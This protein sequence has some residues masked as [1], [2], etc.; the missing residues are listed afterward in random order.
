MNAFSGMGRSL[1]VQGTTG[2]QCDIS[3]APWNQTY[4]VHS[5]SNTHHHGNSTGT[6]E[7]SSVSGL[8]IGAILSVIAD[9]T[10]AVALSIQKL[11]HTRN[12]DEEGNPK[13]HFIKVP[14]WWIGMLMNIFG[15]L[16]NLLAYGFAPASLVAP[17]GCVGVFANEIIAVVFLKEPFRKQDVVG[18]VGVIIG[19]IL[20][21]FGVPESGEALDAHR[22]MSIDPPEYY[23]NPR[24]YV[25]LIFL[26]LLIAFFI[27]YLE[28]RYAAAAQFRRNSGANCGAILAQF[29]RNSLTRSPFSSLPR[30]ARRHLAVWLLLCSMISS[31]TVIA[32]RGWSSLLTQVPDDCFSGLEHCFHGE[33]HHACS[34]TLGTW[35]FWVRI[36]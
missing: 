13:K 10:I 15:E 24:A 25:Y 31:I 7:E 4:A 36:T 14:L 23:A 6:E 28:P 35:M 21:I 30:Y 33:V 22:L 1:L 29:R 9:I 20:I 2:E 5:A 16:G 11:A 12:E 3:M 32:S 34:Q 27:G 19:V 8:V 17:V 18:L 26:L